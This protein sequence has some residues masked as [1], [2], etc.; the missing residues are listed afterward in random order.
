MV[1]QPPTT[2][3]VLRLATLED[4]THIEELDSLSTSPTRDIHRDIEKYFGSV[5]PSTHEHT[6]IFLAF[7]TGIAAA[8]AELMTSLADTSNSIGYIKRVVVHPNFRG[9]GLATLLMQHIIN[10]AYTEQNLKTI[11]LH[12]W[13]GNQPA[14][15]L[16]EALGFEFQHRDLYYR[17]SL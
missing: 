5:D 6:F 8:K 14:I 16:Y 10:F 13:E 7:L 17:L 15:H 4:L 2:S 11:D 12:V 1:D 3:L 9:K